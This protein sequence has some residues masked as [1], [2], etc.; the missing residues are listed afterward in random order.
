MASIPKNPTFM[1]AVVGRIN[2]SA[3][4]TIKDCTIVDYA[5]LAVTQGQAGSYGYWGAATAYPIQSVLHIENSTHSVTEGK[6]NIYYLQSGG[7]IVDS[8]IEQN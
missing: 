5:G 6:E 2:N 8:W 4:I 3:S 7:G 1:G